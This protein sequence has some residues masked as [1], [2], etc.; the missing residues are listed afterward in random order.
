MSICIPMFF[1]LIHCSTSLLIPLF[2][3][4]SC[5]PFPHSFIFH[6][7]IKQFF[8][9]FFYR[10]YLSNSAPFTLLTLP[11]FK[12]LSFFSWHSLI[13][14]FAQSLIRLFVRSSLHSFIDLLFHFFFIYSRLTSFS[15]Q[16]LTFSFLVLFTWT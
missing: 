12:L 5:F 1:F 15:L 7:L 2:F 9:E 3:H 13:I 6:A 4:T 16:S 8:I 10:I 14:S 11:C